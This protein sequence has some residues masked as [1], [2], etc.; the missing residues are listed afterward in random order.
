MPFLQLHSNFGPKNKD[1]LE[2]FFQQIPKNMP[3]AIEFRHTDWFNLP[4]LKN[5]VCE[6]MEDYKVTNIIV[7]T[8]GR[9]DLM[10]M[11]LTTD[12][13]FIRYNGA[14]HD[15]DY[16]RL[17]QWVDRLA[18]WVQGGLRKIYFFIHQNIEL[19]SPLLAAYFIEKLNQ[20]LGTQLAVP[21]L[22]KPE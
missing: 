21:K 19:A 14:N 16:Q 4:D 13:A 1:R 6:L 12:V 7:D 8:A 18:E 5:E 10:H 9:R 20:R 3:I 17:D 11:R 15:S 22:L 2:P